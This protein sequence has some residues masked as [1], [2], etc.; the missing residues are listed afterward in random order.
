MRN[1]ILLV[2]VLLVLISTNLIQA[3]G[4]AKQKIEN[5]EKLALDYYKNGDYKTACEYFIKYNKTKSNV[6]F[7]K[8]DLG[9]FLFFLLDAIG[10]FLFLYLEKR[11]AYKKLVQKNMEWVNRKEPLE[12]FT[13]KD[14]S[15]LDEKEKDLLTRLINLF[16]NEKI[17][18]DSEINI[19]ETAKRLGTNRT[20][21]SKVI[22]SYFNKNFPALLN[23]Y[24]VNEAVRLLMD[25][26]TCNYKMEAIGIMCGYNNRQVFHS[27]F[28]K[29]IGVTPNDFRIMSSSKDIHQ[30]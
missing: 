28:K 22:N 29:E 15:A 21:L 6:D 13:K 2:L 19:N 14:S 26:K 11:R 7:S 8:L 24:R 20:I 30:E 23:E 1:K 10:L 25:A 16:D 27:S 5:N 12:N 3:Q 18:L 9:I 4:K 17:Y